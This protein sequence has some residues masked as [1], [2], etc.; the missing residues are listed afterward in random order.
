MTRHIYL[1]S[2]KGGQGVTTSVVLLAKGF[3][4][5]GLNV[6]VVD[7]PHGDLRAAMGVPYTDDARVPVMDNVEW[8]A[9][10]A[11]PDTDVVIWDN[12]RPYANSYETYVVT[13]NCY[14]SVKRNMYEPGD[15]VIVVLDKGRAL[16]ERDVAAVLGRPLALV[17]PIDNDGI[18][19]KIDAGLCSRLPS[20]YTLPVLAVSAEQ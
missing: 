9:Y 20:R 3:A 18:A 6:V 15:G 14:L 7:T 10:G 8:C 4:S 13:R 11:I 16:T 17:I 12:C 19:K 2:A 1:T 5:Q